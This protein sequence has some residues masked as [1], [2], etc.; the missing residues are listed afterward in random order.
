MSEATIKHFTKEDAERLQEIQRQMAELL[1]EAKQI[2]Q[3]SMSRQVYER[4]RYNTLAHL[5]PGL[6]RDHHWVVNSASLEEVAENA[7]EEA[8]DSE[9]S[10]EEN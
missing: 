9:Q 10:E 2:C 8:K 4:F 3:C 1:D 7:L 5:E 6:I